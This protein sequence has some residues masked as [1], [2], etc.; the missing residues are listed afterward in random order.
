M[1]F[2]TVGA[3]GVQTSQRLGRAKNFEANLADEELL[4]DVTNETAVTGHGSY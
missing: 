2:E 3:E 1:L 4:I